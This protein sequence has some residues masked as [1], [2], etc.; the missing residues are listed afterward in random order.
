MVSNIP[1]MALIQGLSALQNISE[2]H[3]VGLAMLACNFPW[4]CRAA[5]IFALH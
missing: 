3:L 2:D 1:M 5:N 4:G